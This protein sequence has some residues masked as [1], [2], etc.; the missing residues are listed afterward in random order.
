MIFIS[1]GGKKKKLTNATKYLID[2]NGKSRSKAQKKAKLALQKYWF[3]DVVFEELPVLG[4]RMT[5]DFYN[6]TRKVALEIDGEQHYKFNPFFHSG[7]PQKF[8]Q[9]LKRDEQKEQFCEANNIML[10]RILDSETINEQTLSE[11]GLI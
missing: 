1:K 3:A 2:W 11:K 10:V 7:C 4:T 5:L 9:Q 8:A 6:A